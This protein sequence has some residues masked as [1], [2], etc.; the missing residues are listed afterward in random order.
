[1]PKKRVET[2]EKVHEALQNVD[3]VVSREQHRFSV[4]NQDMVTPHLLLTY[5][6]S[7]SGLALYDLREKSQSQNEW[8]IILPG[9]IVNQQ[10]CTDDFVF[11]RIVI[12]QEIFDELRQLYA[13]IDYK[14][15]ILAPTLK[16]TDEQAA[17]LLQI[18]DILAYIATHQTDDAQ[19]RHSLLMAQLFVLFEFIQCLAKEQLQKEDPKNRSAI[20]AHFKQ[21]LVEHYAES[22]SVQFYAEQLNYSPNYF[23]QIIRK[24]TGVSPAEWIEQYIIKR[25]QLLMQTNPKMATSKI[26]HILGFE[27]P[28]NFYRYFKRVTGQTAQEYKESLPS[29]T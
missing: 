17:H 25:A 16:L 27:E 26:A 7:G 2:Y 3:I 13:T 19:L 1:M 21:L 8:A 6:H 20:F 24:E 15:F 23:T 22:R 18:F 11:T 9:H 10:S 4:F 12:A 14:P 5:C 28:V 29:H